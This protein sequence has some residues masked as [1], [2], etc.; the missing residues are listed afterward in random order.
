MPL[1]TRSRTWI[2]YSN[3]YAC[4]VC[5]FSDIVITR[6]YYMNYTHYN[7]RKSKV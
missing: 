3:A 6:Y 5:P 4:F 2:T 7:G 1:E